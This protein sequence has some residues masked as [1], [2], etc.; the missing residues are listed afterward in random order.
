MA[1][2]AVKHYAIAGRLRSKNAIYES[3]LLVLLQ[4]RTIRQLAITCTPAGYSLAVL[5]DH[6]ADTAVRPYVREGDKV[7]RLRPVNIEAEGFAPLHSVR[8]KRVRVYR[9][10]DT[11]INSLK[12][13][14]P[15]PPIYLR[16]G[17]K[18]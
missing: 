17:A 4:R 10:L 2:K 1:I 11:L 14:G 15:L 7:I 18:R 5:S 9:S 12:R 16:Q 3:E 8:N 13:S 6:R